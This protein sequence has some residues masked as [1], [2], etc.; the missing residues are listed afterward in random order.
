MGIEVF[1]IFTSAIICGFLKEKAAS[2][3]GLFVY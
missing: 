2:K 1:H 3:D